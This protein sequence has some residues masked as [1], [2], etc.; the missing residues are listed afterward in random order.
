MQ[1][2]YNQVWHFG[3]NAS[4]KFI[5]NILDDGKESEIDSNYVSATI[6]DR[7]SK[8]DIFHAI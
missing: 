1:N 6:S 2:N 5:D 7:I 4:F 8:S 3:N